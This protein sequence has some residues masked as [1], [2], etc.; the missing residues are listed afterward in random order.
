MCRA[1]FEVPAVTPVLV[2]AA[3]V[4]KRRG[5]SSKQAAAAILPTVCASASAL[6]V[7]LFASSVLAAPTAST[8]SSSSSAKVN[9]NEIKCEICEDGEGMPLH[10]VR[11]VPSTF[12]VAANG[13]TKEQKQRLHMSL[14]QWR[15]P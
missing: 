15:R 9:P 11:N 3:V 8:F 10:F 7:N 5:R 6:P 14:C 13:A 2:A 12:A 4:E 1:V